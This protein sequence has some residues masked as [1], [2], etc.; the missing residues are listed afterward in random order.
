MS[1]QLY[2]AKLQFIFDCFIG[3]VFRNR[4]S[5]PF[6]QNYVYEHSFRFL[7]KVGAGYEEFVTAVRRNENLR[8]DE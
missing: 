6:W 2:C 4:S 8:A 1:C 7:D 5:Y 3:S